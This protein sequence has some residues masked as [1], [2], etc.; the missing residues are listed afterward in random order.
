MKYRLDWREIKIRRRFDSNEE[1]E[2]THTASCLNV[3][4]SCTILL[5]VWSVVW[6]EW[7]EKGKLKVE[8]NFSASNHSPTTSTRRS[9]S[10]SRSEEY[11][12]KGLLG[13]PRSPL[14]SCCL[15]GCFVSSS[16]KSTN[17]R[18]LQACQVL[19]NYLRYIPKGDM[20]IPSRPDKIRL[21]NLE[22]FAFLFRARFLFLALSP[23][24][25]ALSCELLVLLSQATPT[26]IFNSTLSRSRQFSA[27]RIDFVDHKSHHTHARVPE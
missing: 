27:N 25:S 17:S 26:V 18:G 20:N 22:Y 4:F 24:L 1:S 8:R 7:T 10:S 9:E 21:R 12:T 11:F 3:L 2:E 19:R 6:L 13:S 23:L 16:S 15:F 14:R 5:S